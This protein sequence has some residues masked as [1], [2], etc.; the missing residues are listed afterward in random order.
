MII[1][2]IFSKF[3][4]KYELNRKFQQISPS[5]NTEAPEVVVSVDLGFLPA[6]THTATVWM[7][8]KKTAKD[9]KILE[10]KVLKVSPDKP[11][12]I[13]MESA[14]GFVLTVE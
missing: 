3:W 11:L 8:G 6:G 7:D 1:F 4:Q 12:E 10:K 5:E 14:G 2:F 9:P 13:T